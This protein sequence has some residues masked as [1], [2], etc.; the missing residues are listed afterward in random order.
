MKYS[1][2]LPSLAVTV[3]QAFVVSSI[4]VQYEYERQC[5]NRPDCDM[6]LVIYVLCI[7]TVTFQG[8]LQHCQ[9]SDMN[10]DRNMLGRITTGNTA[11]HSQCT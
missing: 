1:A 3:C 9:H 11:L 8:F 4:C 5:D 7:K 10:L 2:F 6:L